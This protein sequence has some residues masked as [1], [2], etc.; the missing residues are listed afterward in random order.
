MISV[1][2]CTQHERIIDQIIAFDWGYLSL[3]N[4]FSVIS[5][6]IATG[7]ILSKLDF[8]DYIPIANSMGLQS[9]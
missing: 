6:N 8:L 1:H 2:M 9:I 4:S 7:N 3:M 5:A